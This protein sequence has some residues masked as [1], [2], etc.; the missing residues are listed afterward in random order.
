M[1]RCMNCMKEFEEDYEV[2]PYCGYIEGSEPKEKYYLK[3]GTILHD[4]YIIGTHVGSGGFGIVY[5]AWDATL[6]RMIAIKEFFP[7]GGYVNRIPG[8]KEIMVFSNKKQEFK[9]E[10]ER[11][12]KEA[13]YLAKFSDHTNIVNVYSFFEENNTAY[14]VMEFLEGIDYREFIKSQGGKVEIET[15]VDVAVS[16]L[17]VLKEMHSQG[18]IHRDVAPDNIFLCLNGKVKLTDF[19]LARL[20]KDEE[21]RE[22]ELKPG[23]APPEQYVR[24]GEL[25]AFTDIYSVGA[26]LY[27]SLTGKMPIEASNRMIEDDLKAPSEINP[28]IP[29]KLNNIIL[30]A[31]ALKPELRFKTDDELI[32]VLNENYNGRVRSI[33]EEMIYRKR[34]RLIK[35][36]MAV[37]VICLCLGIGFFVY[38][39]KKS[40]VDLKP[41][42]LEVWIRAQN[43]NTKAEDFLDALSEFSER[44]PNVNVRVNMIPKDQYESKLREAAN[45]HELPDVYETIEGLELATKDLSKLSEYVNISEYVGL[46]S[47]TN[48]KVTKVPITY[49]IPVVYVSKIVDGYS[50]DGAKK[51]YESMLKDGVFQVNEDEV[52]EFL[53][54]N[55]AFVVADT[56]YYWSVQEQ[57]GGKYE[58]LPIPEV[59]SCQA[60]Y[61][62]SL[63]I[64]KD[65]DRAQYNAAI[66]MIHYLLGEKAQSKLCIEQHY[67]LPLQK[68]IYKRYVQLNLEYQVLETEKSHLNFVK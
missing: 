42:S 21:E 65:T 5:R 33:E 38:D 25:G 22:V 50:D 15:A 37:C 58:M 35:S 23:F 4:R 24:N 60:R 2:C 49:A 67:D 36:L 14:I 53:K 40:E 31:M 63:S 20:S 54:G 17:K 16:I 34:I 59:E 30:R 56:S 66:Q 3:P 12:L 39:A 19:G 28:E 44:Y 18:I 10:L 9:K 64:D 32:E 27:R 57:Q 1:K 13:Q 55:R 7:M 51:A 52:L 43:R 48:G 46:D 47:L 8:Y 45:N 26:V 6:S 62:M 11:F 29:E 41:A 61:S 68:D